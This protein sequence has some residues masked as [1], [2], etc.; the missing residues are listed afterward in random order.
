MEMLIGVFIDEA[1]P[2]LVIQV[3]TITVNAAPDHPE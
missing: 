1:D 2:A 3:I